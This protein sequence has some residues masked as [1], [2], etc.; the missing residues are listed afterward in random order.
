MKRLLIGLVLC[1]ALAIGSVG[2]GV[3]QNSATA[4]GAK[5]FVCEPSTLP[6]G[7]TWVYDY[8]EYE[9]C[10]PGHQCCVD[11]YYYCEDDSTVT[12]MIRRPAY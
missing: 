9:Q 10:Q 5:R 12:T 6:P 7:C 8:S 2:V 11:D 1:T 3:G 4:F